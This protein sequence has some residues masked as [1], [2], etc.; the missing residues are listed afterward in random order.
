MNTYLANSL[1]GAAVASAPPVLKAQDLTLA[2]AGP[3]GPTIAVD[4]V[5]LQIARGERL[6]LLGQSGCGKSSILKALAGFLK[7]VGGKITL[8]GKPV[9]GSG[10]DRIVVFQEFDQLLP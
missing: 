2:Y 5:S 7:P 8:H 6:V 4:R 9:T 3:K 10:P 1:A